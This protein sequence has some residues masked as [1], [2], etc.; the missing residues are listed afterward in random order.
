MYFIY[1]ISMLKLSITVAC[2]YYYC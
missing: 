1:S 2:V